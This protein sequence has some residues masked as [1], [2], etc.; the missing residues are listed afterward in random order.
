MNAFCNL[1]GAYFRML[2]AGACLLAASTATAQQRIVEWVEFASVLD[3]DSIALGYPVPVPVDTPLPF[4]GFRSY[5][6]LD[7]RH[8]ELEATTPWVHGVEIGRTHEDR[9]IM[10]YRLGD[11]D[12]ETATGLPEQAMLTNA[13]IHA[14]E[15][16]T[17]E[18]ATG[19]MELIALG[20]GDRHL[21]DY[22]RDNAN[23]LVIPV[24]NVDGF[25]QTQRYPGL[26]WLGTDD[27][28]PDTSPRDGR[29]RRKNMPGVDH[30]I[31]TQD[32]HLLGVDLNRNN[33]PFWADSSG[34]SPNPDS[35][36]HHGAA[37][38]SEPE[39]R[40]LDAAAQH[41]PA[42]RL[43]MYTDVH[44]FT[45]VHLWDRNSNLRLGRLTERLLETFTVHHQSFPAGKYY[46][47]D[48]IREVIP[49]VGIGTTA[50]YFTHTYQVPS[51]TLEMEPSGGDHPGLPGAGADYG[52]LG[53]NGHDGFILPESEITRV[54]TEMAQTFAVGYYQQAGPPSVRAMRLIDTKTGAVVF[55]AEWDTLDPTRRTLFRNVLQPLQ[56][57]RDYQAWI[58]WDKPM[59]WR[60]NG[61]VTT[62]P[63]KP[64]AT[65]EVTRELTVDGGPLGVEFGSVQWLSEPGDA[66]GGVLRYRDDAMRFRFR[67]PA[68]ALN[69]QLAADAPLATLGLG[70]YDMVGWRNDADPATVV[71]W[72]DGAWAGYED[73]TG[74]DD[75][76]QG[77]TDRTIAVPLTGDLPGDPFTVE[78]GTSAAWFDPSRNGE[79]FMLEV[80]ADQRAVMYWFTY[81]DEGRQDWFVA[82]GEIRGN[83]MLF[84]ELLRVSGGVFGPDFD[85]EQ[86]VRTSVGSAA[87]TWSSCEAGVFK[88]L[89]DGDGGPLRQGRMNL[90]RLSSVM[91]IEC[92]RPPDAAAQP[93]AALSG[94]W[95]DPNH[96]GEG[97]ALEILADGR[98]LVY[99]FSFD[100]DGQRRWFYGVGAMEDGRVVFDTL[101]T[102]GGA[103]FGADFDPLDVTLSDWGSLELELG[104]DA[105]R[106]RFQPTESG[107]AAGQLDLVRLTHLDGLECD[108]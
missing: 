55:D 91:G 13:G 39:T 71:S 42:N 10:L 63:G 38:A 102:T 73:S 66:P 44:S 104:C 76:D 75:T 87:F 58:A 45:Q 85:P 70:A 89:L 97:Y 108:S 5:A 35:L 106:A 77:G 90:A 41:G 1:F 72:E 16:Q 8:R 59:R 12:L 22:L 40:A 62:L 3:R 29:M 18:V 36:I 47:Y 53:R 11:D 88:W 100:A 6:G 27:R 7:A 14:R 79:G 49:N 74:A 43:A 24:L 9:P 86:V 103:G 19:I 15:W 50:E 80:L 101:N 107:F 81:D 23:V 67:L 51:W 33:D 82:V 2:L 69:T 37:P 54:R 46:Y 92:G 28:Y 32:D 83:R 56:L 93:A 78:P 94:S 48:P 4:D 17:P 57:D 95:Y 26:N 30:L 96:S 52:G 61:A 64:A 31:E 25:L 84:P 99:W 105:G 98:T 21:V 60:I 34:S 65:L 20:G 68:D